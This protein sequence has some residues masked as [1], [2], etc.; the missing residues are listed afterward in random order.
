MFGPVLN[1]MPFVNST[2][3]TTVIETNLCLVYYWIID[4]WLPIVE[5]NFVLYI[6]RFIFK[7]ANSNTLVSERI[8][9]W[10]Y[11]VQRNPKLQNINW[12]I[13]TNRKCNPKIIKTGDIFQS[14][15]RAHK[16]GVH[17][18][19]FSLRKHKASTAQREQFCYS[20]EKKSAHS[21]RRNLV[22]L[23]KL[24]K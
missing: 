6:I 14:F 13:T 9:W 11:L 8:L 23:T 15:T 10:N 5:T 17:G 4:N 7:R 1:Y 24:Y 22:N 19:N 18:F 20:D 16:S 2:T 12:K 3:A 21:Q